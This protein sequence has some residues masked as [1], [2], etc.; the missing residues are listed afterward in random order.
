MHIMQ[1][2]KNRAKTNS[3]CGIARRKSRTYTI[4]CR[5]KC[6]RLLSLRNKRT[7]QPKAKN[8]NGNLD[9]KETRNGKRYEYNLLT[10]N[11]DGN[12]YCCPWCCCNCYGLCGNLRRRRR[13]RTR[14][15]HQRIRETWTRRQTKSEVFKKIK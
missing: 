9:L 4:Y 8:S 2:S 6:Q 7:D 15:R 12:G 3:T 1:S 14:W 11:E 10:D 5:C 13:R